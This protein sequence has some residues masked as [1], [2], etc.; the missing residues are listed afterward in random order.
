MTGVSTHAYMSR[1]IPRTLT[2]NMFSLYRAQSIEVLISAPWTVLGAICCLQQAGPPRPFPRKTYLNWINSLDPSPSWEANI[3]LRVG[4][5]TRQITS[6]P[7]QYSEFIAHSLLHLHNLQLHKCC[8]LQYHNYFYC[9]HCHS[10]D[11]T[12]LVAAGLHSTRRFHDPHSPTEYW[13]NAH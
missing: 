1:A 2:I 3:F 5:I 6:R 7:I 12:Q 4:C 8:H 11:A 10:L 9:S 13:L